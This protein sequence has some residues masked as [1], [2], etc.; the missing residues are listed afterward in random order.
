[1]RP[2]RSRVIGSITV[3]FLRV[4]HSIPDCVGLALHTPAGT[5][6]HTG[7]FK[8][9]QTPLDGQH[10]DL[11]RF[12]TLGSEGVLALL[13]D[14]TNIDRRGFTGSEIDVIGAFEEIFTSATGM[15]VV[16]TFS[17]SLFRVQI[18]V[19]LAARFGRKVAFVGRGMMQNSVIAQR[20]GHLT[21]PEGVQIRDSE[22]PNYPPSQVLCISTGT[23]GEPRSAL[24]RIAVDDHKHVKVGPGDTVV[25]SARA[26]PG[27]EKA[28]GRVINHLTRRGAEIITEAS[29]HVHVSG[30]GSEEEIKL[31]HSLVRPQYFVPVHGEFRHLAEHKRIAERVTA[32]SSRPVEVR[33]IENGDIL[34]FDA[35]GAEVVGK[36]PTGRVLIDDTRVG[37]VADEVLRDRRHL[38]EDGIVLPVVAVRKQD[39]ELARPPE[40]ITRGVVTD[41]S[42]DA[43]GVDARAVAHRRH[44]RIARGGA[45]G[46]RPVA[47]DHPRRTA[48]LFQ[49]T[50]RPPPPG[51]AGRHG[52]LGDTERGSDFDAVTQ[53]ERVRRR[54]PFRRLA[55]LAHRA[56][57]A[58]SRRDPVWFFTVGPTHPPANFVGLVGAFVAEAVVPAAGLHLV[59][60]PGDPRRAGLELLLVPHGGCR[61]HQVGGRRRC[62]SAAWRRSSASCSARPKWP[63]GR[64]APA[65]TSAS[66]SAAPRAPTSIGR[67]RSS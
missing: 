15:L 17:S 1:M 31:I 55:H 66:G 37:E 36:A 64:S 2:G 28:I 59:P 11:H 27:N 51:A 8:V 26:I 53:G 20:L 46:P 42:S 67:A 32:G 47:R 54:R 61:L 6:V 41:A 56:G 63:A 24:S 48:T 39:G 65:A 58:T 62:L 40:I 35:E 50:V 49:T 14:S 60:R 43:L 23:Q 57:D 21:V 19:R 34:R 7:D 25:M 13:A 44:R 29:K 12:A 18:L 33:L 3:E 30:H 52:N 16:A 9:D 5:L 38:A 10:V 45:H 22:V 4:T